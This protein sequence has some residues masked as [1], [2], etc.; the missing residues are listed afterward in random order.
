[1]RPKIFETK[2]PRARV[3]SHDFDMEDWKPDARTAAAT[4]GSSVYLWI[5]PAH[6]A[7]EW[8]TKDGAMTLTQRFQIFSG[9]GSDAERAFVIE[10]GR[11]VGA[12]AAFEIVRGGARRTMTARVDG[13][14]LAGAGLEATRTRRASIDLAAAISDAPR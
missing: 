1:M 12:D 10:N 11:L 9:S 14:A 4:D 5:V 2:R 8:K 6:I 13:D 3:V 7:G